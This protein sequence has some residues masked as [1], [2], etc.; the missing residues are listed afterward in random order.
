MSTSSSPSTLKAT[1][2]LSVRSRVS[3]AS[4]AAGAMVALAVYFLFTLLGIAIGLEVAIR[5]DVQI[6]A[7]AA[8]YSIATL[9]L[10]MFLGGWATSRLAVGESKLE[11][12]LYGV[13]L[14]GVLFV[15][16]F[17]LVGVGVRVGFGAMMGLASGAVV[18]ADE[19]PSAAASTG[20]MNRLVQ[21]YSSEFGGDK[22]VSDLTKIGVEQDRARQIQT[23]M[24]DRLDTLRNDPAALGAQVQKDLD[25]P[26]ARQTAAQVVEG[27]RRASWYTLAG[28]V[29]SMAAVILGSLIGSGDLPV[30]V[31]VLGVRRMATDPRM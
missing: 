4:I 30:P 13:I 22:F 5:S 20:A 28:V 1:D 9:L 24:K 19:N 12:V 29:I 25:N 15:G 6:G 27:T 16:M 8:I 2:L 21:R 31:P 26:E 23:L 18:V 3:W 11:A 14:W 17:W 7:G 10:S